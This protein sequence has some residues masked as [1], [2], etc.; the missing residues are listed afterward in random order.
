M[1]QQL[2]TNFP[3]V[4]LYRCFYLSA[5]APGFLAAITTT[6]VIE[7]FSL[8]GMKSRR[9]LHVSGLSGHRRVTN[10]GNPP[11]S[12]HLLSL[13]EGRFIPV[14][15]SSALAHLCRLPAPTGNAC[16]G[17]SFWGERL[18]IAPKSGAACALNMW[19]R[20][21]NDFKIARSAVVSFNV[22]I[23]WKSSAIPT[24]PPAHRQQ[25]LQ[26]SASL[27]GAHPPAAQSRRWPAPGSFCRGSRN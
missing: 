25:R 5:Q 19:A 16:R 15:Q 8:N 9:N 10:P 6:G 23:A 14:R 26:S 20:G 18:A 17:F 1:K 11:E 22:A 27:A 3:A 12:N 7:I 24:A 4:T 21:R 2:N 13:P